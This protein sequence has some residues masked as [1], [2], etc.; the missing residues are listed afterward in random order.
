[1][2][3][4][5]RAR[6]RRAAG[7]LEEVRHLPADFPE[8]RPRS[9]AFDRWATKRL[10]AEPSTDLIAEGIAVLGKRERKRILRTN[11]K[12]YRVLWEKLR[13]DVGDAALAEQMLLAGAVLAGLAERSPPDRDLLALIEGAPDAEEEEL[14]ALAID[15]CDVWSLADVVAALAAA[16]VG[17]PRDEAQPEPHL[18]REAARL[19]TREHRARLA[20]L[21]ANLAARLPVEGFPLASGRLAQ[22]CRAFER[23]RRLRERVAAAL[24]EV[25]FEHRLPQLVAALA[26]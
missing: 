6:G 10:P 26:A 21:V 13:A 12:R 16:P 5:A 2:T 9:V 8:L 14:L 1:V 3:A 17:E 7:A 20:R 4:E 25:S 15:G 22:A 23:D 18:R 11:G 19:A 24:L